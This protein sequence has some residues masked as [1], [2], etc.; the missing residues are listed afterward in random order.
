MAPKGACDAVSDPIGG[1]GARE[2]SL[3]AGHAVCLRCLALWMI[4]LGGIRRRTLRV[5]CF[6]FILRSLTPN[7]LSQGRG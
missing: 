4:G 2:R 5:G 3:S 1:M 7:P 6:V